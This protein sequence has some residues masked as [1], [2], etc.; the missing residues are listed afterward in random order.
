MK[1]AEPL[2]ILELPP[3]SPHPGRRVV[4]FVGIF[5]SLLPRVALLD[6]ESRERVAW[7]SVETP[8]R[9]WQR[10]DELLIAEGDAGWLLP[11]LAGKGLVAD[12]GERVPG[13][14]GG[15]RVCWADGYLLDAV[16][17]ADAN[18][19]EPDVAVLARSGAMRTMFRD[20]Q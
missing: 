19:R 16:L 10:D 3:G 20:R 9:R 6:A 17:K 11:W 8:A 18:G 13:A 4:L 7:A 1:T 15:A 12:T 14:D 5:V 2:L